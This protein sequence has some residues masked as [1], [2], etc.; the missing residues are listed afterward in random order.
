MRTEI[1]VPFAFDTAPIEKMLEEVGKDEVTKRI[2]EL[3]KDYVLSAIPKEG[4]GWHSS[5]DGWYSPGNKPDWKSLVIR[6]VD[7]FLDSHSK[8][9]IDEAAVLL[10]MRAGRKAAWRD[11]LAEYKEAAE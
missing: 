3:I 7:A 11:V 10:A 9:I 8:E 4:D 1:V 6:R 5:G 2:D